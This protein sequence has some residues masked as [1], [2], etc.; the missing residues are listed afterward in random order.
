MDKSKLKML[1]FFDAYSFIHFNFVING[2]IRKKSVRNGS[3]LEETKESLNSSARHI[4]ILKLKVV[5]GW[6][7][8]LGRKSFKISSKDVLKS[9]HSTLT[10]KAKNAKQVIAK[11]V[12]KYTRNAVFKWKEFFFLWG[13]KSFIFNFGIFW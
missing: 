4:E 3:T 7:S 2:F 11:K 6:K 10:K 9:M 12:L 8:F 13:L 1:D 5:L